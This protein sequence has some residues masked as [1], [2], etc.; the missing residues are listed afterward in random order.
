MRED[1]GEAKSVLSDYIVIRAL[2][3]GVTVIGPSA[4][5]GSFVE[6]IS[7]SPTLVSIEMLAF[8][9]MSLRSIILPDNLTNIGSG[10]F[11]GCPG[12]SEIVIPESVLTIG[13]EAFCFC[14][15]LTIRVE[16]ASQPEGWDPNWHDG[17]CVIVWGYIPA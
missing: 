1:S 8:A 17:D 6:H 15:D 16:A 5:M 14:G 7:L 2:E 9:G 11:M 4:F 3:N 13:S 12:L 10:A